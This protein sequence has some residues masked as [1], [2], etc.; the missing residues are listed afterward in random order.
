VEAAFWRRAISPKSL[1]VIHPY[2]NVRV[3]YRRPW[4][5]LERFVL[6]SVDAAVAGNPGAAKVLSGRGFHRPVYT[7]RTLGANEKDFGTTRLGPSREPS[8]P[9]MPIIGFSGRIFSGKGLHILLE[10]AARMKV[11]A[12]LLVVGDGPRL[13]EARAQAIRLGIAGSIRWVGAVPTR[14]MGE[15]YSSM[16][17]YAAPTI[18]RPGDM[19]DWKEQCPRAHI[20]AMLSGLPIV[21]SDGG[22]NRWTLGRAGIIVPQGDSAA[23]A[24]ALDRLCSSA[25]LRRAIRQ[26]AR[27]R[28][29]ECFT[30]EK[31]ASGL[32]AIW[33]KLLKGRA[34]GQS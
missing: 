31:A 23:L 6:R 26:R 22:E 33:K 8:G 13:A 34:H 7:L 24:R 25:A 3:D 10:A 14:R 1:L 30:W 28:A 29:V 32:I 17:I 5:A 9:V 2:Q 19:P 18:D 15:Y 4:P 20:E 16:D 12:G 27:A 21:A 11:R